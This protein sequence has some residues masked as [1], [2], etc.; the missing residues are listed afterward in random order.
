[1]I[2]SALRRTIFS[3]VILAAILCLNACSSCLG[4][5]LEGKYSDASGAFK[6]ELN[7]GGKATLTTLNSDTPCT[8]KVDG[9]QV[10]LQ[11]ENQILSFTVQDDG[12]LMPPPETQIGR[13]TK[14]KH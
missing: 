11:C 10:T 14:A 4:S 5:H 13:L 1:M 3:A 2:Q 7:S 6:V 12:S 8:Y 9:K